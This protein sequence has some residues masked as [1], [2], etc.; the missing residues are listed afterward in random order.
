VNLPA[1]ELAQ[2][3]GCSPE[4]LRKNRHRLGLTVVNK[5]LHLYPLQKSLA[6]LRAQGFEV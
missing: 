5:R 4:T 6:A 1:K 3:V 2:R